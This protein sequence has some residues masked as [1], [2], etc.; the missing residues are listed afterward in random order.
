MTM[1]FDETPEF[2]RDCRRLNKKY[3]TLPD[4]LQTFRNT[5]A[6]RPLGGPKN[7]R[8]ITSTSRFRIIKARVHCR[9]LTGPVLRV[10]YAY[11]EAE[12]RI[13]FIE[14]Y[15]KGDKE[16]EDQERIQRYLAANAG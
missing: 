2:R 10:V 14:L 3:R 4:D 5:V 13:E 6:A 1:K 7:F 11:V 16:N 9:Y 8:A 15:F 12:Q